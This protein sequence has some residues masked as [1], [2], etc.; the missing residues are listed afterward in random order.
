MTITKLFIYIAIFAVIMLVGA[1]ATRRTKNLVVNFFQFFVGGLFIFSGFVK[2]VD[3]IGTAI[4]MEEYFEV[5]VEYLP[6]LT[7]FWHFMANHALAVGNIMILLEIF[8]G[9]TLLFGKYKK[10]TVWLILL[11]MVFFTILTAFSHVT[12]KVTDCG[13]FGDFMKLTPFTSFI[14]DIIL[15]TFSLILFFG[16]KKIAELL[17]PNP[18]TAAVWILTAV[19]IWFTFRNIYNLPIVDFR[20]YKIGVNIHKCMELPPDAKPYKYETIFIYKNKETGEEKQFINTW[21]EDFND[22]DYVDRKDKLLQKGDDPKCKDFV[23]YDAD[24]VNVTE[25][26]LHDDGFIVVISSHDIKK[27]SKKGFKRMVDI[28]EEAERLGHQVVG[29]TGSTMD[30]VEAFR[31]EIGLAIPFYNLDAVPIKTMNRSNPGITVLQGGTIVGKYH[32][33]EASSYEKLR[34]KLIKN[35]NKYLEH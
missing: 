35:E 11:I 22:W 1:M 17:K 12:G 34:S 16:H 14:K 21:P 4:K 6:I 24:G 23:L 18:R 19:S 5:F 10:L 32:H 25:N 2:A 28:A 13:C 31:H 3:P 7:G 33:R 27:A 8:L 30:D 29:F 20:A 26:V 15:T 9:F